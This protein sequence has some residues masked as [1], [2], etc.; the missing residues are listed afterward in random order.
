MY[1]QKKRIFLLKADV[2]STKTV[3]VATLTYPLLNNKLLFKMKL[4]IDNSSIH[5]IT[6]SLCD[7]SRK[8]LL[9]STSEK[10]MVLSV[11]LVYQST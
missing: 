5:K 8:V 10:C 11:K 3:V 6:L 1:K 9:G 7:I 4:A 2:F